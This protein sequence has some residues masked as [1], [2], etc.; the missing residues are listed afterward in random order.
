MA[1]RRPA[2]RVDLARCTSCG[3][4]AAAWEH[5]LGIALCERCWTVWGGY[6]RYRMA[7]VGS[8]ALRDGAVVGQA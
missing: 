5:D 3:E 1:A 7:A 8:V 6:M 4:P 2:A